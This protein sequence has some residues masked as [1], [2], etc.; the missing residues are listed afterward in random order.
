VH[1]LTDDDDD[2]ICA[3]IWKN[4]RMARLGSVNNDVDKAIS[5]QRS[6]NQARNVEIIEWIKKFSLAY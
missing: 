5:L 3:W 1:N 4:S 6:T 2:K